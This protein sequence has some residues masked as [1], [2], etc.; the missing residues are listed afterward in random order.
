MNLY[1]KHRPQTFSE[2][3]GQS[4]ISQTLIKQL[5]SGKIAHAYL[6][7]GPRGTGKTTTARVFA[8]ALNCQSFTGETFGEPCNKCQNC[9]AI[10]DGRYLDVI[11]I[12]AASN[13]GIDEIRELREKINLA[14]MSGKFKVY[15]IDEA[16]QLTGEAFNALL[17]TLE[18]P[19][20]HAIFILATTEPHKIPA[21]I[22]SRV[23]KFDFSRATKMSLTEKLKLVA[24]KEHSKIS[25][26]ALSTIA[27]QAE[28]SY[29]DAEVLLEKIIS[30]KTDPTDQEVEEILG[31][32]LS[33]DLISL[34]D[35]LL[36]KKTKEA[37]IWFE[38]YSAKG[39]N[40]KV[41]LESTLS[42]LQEIL[43]VKV[44]A[45]TDKDTNQTEE[46]FLHLQSLASQISN[47]RLASWIRLFS[48]ATTELTDSPVPE[49]PVELA[50]VEACDFAANGEEIEDTNPVVEKVTIPEPVAEVKIVTE[51]KVK[52]E[53]AESKKSKKPQTGDMTLTSL[54]E[55]WNEVLQ[56]VKPRNNS[57]EIFLRSAVP[58]EIEDDLVILE[59]GYKFHKDRLE[60]T[61]NSTIL[62]EVLSE[63]LGRPVRIKG[64]VGAKVERKTKTEAPLE[65]VDPVEIFGKLV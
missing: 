44:G 64:K 48:T 53:I 65:E 13:R 45:V 36:L 62:A 60:E 61:K 25:E 46:D 12:D 49:L 8:K 59:V 55:K 57:L 14:P 50:L 10:T 40:P 2:I 7:S 38:N 39:G 32:G 11:E 17:K 52:E 3:I 1:R 33:Q 24:K 6:F 9:L 42:L 34:V 58:S 30:I 18:E 22:Q 19:P 15:I 51:P 35:L 47:E 31:A 63:V 21:T 28:G 43:L 29:R 23:Q 5:E 41:F 56:K 4:H 37:V 54:Q 26:T 20:A 27:K 16:H